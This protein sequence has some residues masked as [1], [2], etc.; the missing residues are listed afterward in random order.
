MDDFITDAETGLESFTGEVREFLY[1]VDLVYISLLSSVFFITLIIFDIAYNFAFPGRFEVQKRRRQWRHGG[2]N[3]DD[4]TNWAPAKPD[5]QG[6]ALVY[7]Y[8]EGYWRDR[9]N[10]LAGVVHNAI[11]T[12]AKKLSD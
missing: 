9:S 3:R 8:S 12:T 7:P 1:G 6:G 11:E 10:D 5:G 2:G 4:G